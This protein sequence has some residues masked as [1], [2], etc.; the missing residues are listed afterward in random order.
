M[1]KTSFP[2]SSQGDQ[3]NVAAR[4]LKLAYGFCFH[5]SITEVLF[6]SYKRS[7]WIARFIHKLSE[8]D[9]QWSFQHSL[10]SEAGW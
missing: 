8:L 9:C 6:Q 3:C 1:D 4:S 5:L 2:H 7:R 10:G